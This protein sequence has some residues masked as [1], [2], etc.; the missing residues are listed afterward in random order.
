MLLTSTRN[1]Y[2]LLLLS[3][4]GALSVAV[5]VLAVASST[6]AQT[7]P[8]PTFTKTASPNPATVGEVII[9]EIVETNNTS[10]PINASFD[11]SFPSSLQYVPGTF[12]AIGN[13][14]GNCF[15]NTTEPV[16]NRVS[17]TFPLRPGATGGCRVGFRPT[18][19]GLLTNT[20]TDSFGQTAS[21]T[22]C[23]QTPGGSECSAPPAPPAPGQ[24]PDQRPD[25]RQG[26]V[27]APITQEGEQ[28]SEAGEIDQSFDV[29]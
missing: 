8:T 14:L 3:V 13:S 17:G 24:R 25:Q 19:P 6:Q 28:E 15:L 18:E 9:F 22:V 12:A 5:G 2:Y 21:V 27:P 23:V 7:V 29:S 10:A 16:K 4:L 11:D 20:A 1:I 26:G